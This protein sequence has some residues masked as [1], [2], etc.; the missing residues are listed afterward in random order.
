MD[1]LIV[2]SIVDPKCAREAKTRACLAVL[3]Y[4]GFE[5]YQKIDPNWHDWGTKLSFAAETCRELVDYTHI[6]FLDARDV[7]LLAG[8]DEVMERYY[9]FNHPWVYGTQDSIWPIP[10]P[11]GPE[12]Y[13][14]CRSG[15]RYLN[16]GMCLGERKH[17]ER[18]YRQWTDNWT[19][20][21]SKGVHSEQLWMAT[22]FL[23]GYPEA[24]K[25]DNNCELFQCPT[26]H[27]CKIMPGR[28]HNELTGTD[29]LVIHF[30]GGRDVTTPER[31][32]LWNH[33]VVA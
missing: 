9:Q 31:K 30:N 3:K 17:M 15:Y 10:S 23:E 20:D 18:Y 32:I 33:W 29:P 27:W 8:P 12:D 13:P 14:P 19:V 28:L 2:A 24:I 7:I 26:G 1:K 11:F 16:G 22:R 21:I 25:L 6:L 5:V 4:H